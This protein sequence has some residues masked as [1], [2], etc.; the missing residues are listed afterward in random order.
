MF[1]ANVARFILDVYFN[2]LDYYI[3]IIL[4]NL[5]ILPHNLYNRRK[6][7]VESIESIEIVTIS[8][9]AAGMAA[10]E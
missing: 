4:K 8:L 3:I 5:L 2:I 10:R 1:E 7:R 6:S 9:V